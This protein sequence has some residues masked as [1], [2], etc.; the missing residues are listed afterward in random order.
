MKYNIQILKNIAQG[1]LSRCLI[2]GL[3]AGFALG[4]GG[5]NLSAQTTSG[6]EAQTTSASAESPLDELT[7]VEMLNSVDLGKNYEIVQKFQEKEAKNKLY[8]D[9]PPASKGG[10]CTIELLRNREGLV[11]TIP[12]RLLFAPNDTELKESASKYLTPI[13]RYLK[14]PDLYR[15]MLAMHTDNTGS[16]QYREE[17][18]ADRV[19]AV[20]EWF[21]EH[22]SPTQYLFPYALGDD[23]P[24]V[25]NTSMA[26]RDTNRRL[27]IYLV[28]GEK[29]LNMA[30]K[31]RIE[32]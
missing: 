19:D 21:E 13:K 11:I 5:F 25:P 16:D 30:K 31:G 3:F 29:M 18:T 6:V 23:M 32:M 15:V 1:K 24:R 7:F 22:G 4:A 10:E 26:D 17:L 14:E 28:P 9:Y 2:C 27:E 20:Y 12:A 8:A